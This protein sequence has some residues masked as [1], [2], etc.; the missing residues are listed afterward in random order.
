MSTQPIDQKPSSH[1]SST[2]ITNSV[3]LLKALF[4]DLYTSLGGV[5]NDISI[6]AQGMASVKEQYDRLEKIMFSALDLLQRVQPGKELPPNWQAQREALVAEACKIIDH[7]WQIATHQEEEAVPSSSVI[8]H[9]LETLTLTFT[10]KPF[11]NSLLS[12]LDR[13]KIPYTLVENEMQV[14]LPAGTVQEE[15]V[16]F[17]ESKRYCV[18]IPDVP[19][20]EGRVYFVWGKRY[21]VHLPDGD[22]FYYLQTSANVFL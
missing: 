16:D 13:K 21:C 10:Q 6:Y 2:T 19:V 14:S 7:A 18:Y 3:E 22:V 9:P 1:T 11:Q 12:W 5:V 4:S 8:P 15:V 20:K 17:A